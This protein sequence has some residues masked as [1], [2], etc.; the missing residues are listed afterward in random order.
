[1]LESDSRKTF[2]PQTTEIALLDLDLRRAHKAQSP[3]QPN[4]QMESIGNYFPIKTTWIYIQYQ[5]INIHYFGY[6][7]TPTN[8]TLFKVNVSTYS[9]PFILKFKFELHTI[10]GRS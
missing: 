9:I 5:N 8:R 2:V 4:P 6:I 1:M 3:T 10:G 7:S